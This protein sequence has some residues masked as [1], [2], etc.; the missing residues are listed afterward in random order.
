[1]ANNN[2]SRIKELIEVINNANKAYYVD[3]NPIMSDYEFDKLMDELIDLEKKT[4][5]MFANSPSKKVG[6]GLSVSLNKVK[7]SKPMLSAQK[8]KDINDIYTFGNKHP[9]VISWKLDGLSIILRYKDGEFYQAL[10]R[11]EDG[12]VGEDV[13]FNVI[14][15]RHVPKR[16]SYKGEFEVRGEGVISYPDFKVVNRFNEQSHPRNVAS[17]AIRAVNQDKGKLSHIDFIAFELI[18][19]NQKY[20]T[21]IETF[22]FLSSNGFMVVDH[23]LIENYDLDYLKEITDTFDPKQFEYPVDGLIYEFNDIEFGNGLGATE[24]HENRM[25]A[26]KWSDDLYE[27]TFR[28]IKMGNSKNGL[29]TLTALFD[30]VNIDGASIKQADL[31]SLS[32]YEKYQFGIGDRIK[33]YK[34]NMIVPQVEENL[35]RSDTYVLRDRCPCCGAKLETRISSTGVKNLYCPNDNCI[36][37]NALKIAKFCDSSGMN[38]QGLSASTLEE[39]MSYGYIKNYYDIYRLKEHRDE[40]FSIPGFGSKS[41][42][43]ILESIENSKRCHL[44]QF[45]LAVDIPSM[46]SSAS[47]MI[48]EYFY[49]SYAKFE[50]ALKKEFPLY[51]LA[52]VSESLSR[53]I[54]NW[55]NENKDKPEYISLLKELTFITAN[56]KIST[57]N[58]VI[59]ITGNIN[60]MSKEDTKELLTLM[61]FNDIRDDID[62]DVTTLFVGYN[63]DNNIV[64]K[65]VSKGIVVVTNSHFSEY[66]ANLKIG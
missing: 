26:L 57:N 51:H 19:F 44:Y 38:I 58:Q 54:Y 63:P 2:I 25:I 36:G 43:N 4:G 37:T 29:I 66:C 39:I 16:V 49:G 13:T 23:E 34:A 1:M 11:G 48:D 24:H 20:K 50:D 35:D 52:N 27:T 8:S 5:I 30:E 45:L 3:D 32:N 15:I 64:G 56:N 9:I 41:I 7:H 28:G 21:K 10:T 62:D 18:D 61:G 60:N 14:N 40:L 53:N 22:D 59:A 31:H 65:A 46:T 47:Q 17:G 55:Y 42:N 12:L 33:V 6:G